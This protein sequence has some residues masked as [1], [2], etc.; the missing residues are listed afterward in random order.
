MNKYLYGTGI[1]EFSGI[2]FGRVMNAYLYG[3]KLTTRTNPVGNSSSVITTCI[4]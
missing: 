1:C 2:K 3:S 4:Y